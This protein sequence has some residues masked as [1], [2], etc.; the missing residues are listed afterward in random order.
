MQGN[1]VK[2][3]LGLVLIY[4]DS[5]LFAIKIRLC[6][7]PFIQIFRSITHQRCSGPEFA[8][9]RKGRL[10]MK[11]RSNTPHPATTTWEKI[12]TFVVK[13]G[14]INDN[15]EPFILENSKNHRERPHFQFSTPNWTSGKDTRGN[16][17]IWFSIH[18]SPG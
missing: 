5:R 8:Q 9:P 14:S 12:R 11:Q 1:H 15:V 18:K 3:S 2:G 13:D 17:V 7:T 4:T 16:W 10:K 6:P